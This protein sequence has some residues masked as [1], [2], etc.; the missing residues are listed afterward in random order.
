MDSIS[1]LK[2]F[3]GLTDVEDKKACICFTIDYY[4]DIGLLDKEESFLI[5]NIIEKNR[6]DVLHDKEISA[7]YFK[8]RN[9]IKKFFGFLPD[10]YYYFPEGDW[11]IRRRYMDL[12]VKHLENERDN[13]LKLEL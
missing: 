6:P 9:R 4:E 1:A 3:I 10:Q 11:N 13:V 5:K 2:K 7:S 12:L 8:E